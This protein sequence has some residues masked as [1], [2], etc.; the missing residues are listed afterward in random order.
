VARR[1][2]QGAV[3]ILGLGVGLD[4]SPFYRRCL[5]T[6]MSQALDNNLFYEI[7]Q[8]IGGRHRR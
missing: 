4:L 7:V 2:G 1:E 3:E 6:D 8:L 5:A